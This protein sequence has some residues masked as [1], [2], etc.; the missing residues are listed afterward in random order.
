MKNKRIRLF[1]VIFAMLFVLTGCAEPLHELTEEEEELIVH[2]SAYAVA[3]YN[4]Y[5]KDGMTSAELSEDDMNETEENTESE[6][7]TQDNTGVNGTTGQGNTS[8]DESS[9][10]PKATTSLAKAVG[11]ENLTVTYNGL[12]VSE[13]YQEGGY[14]S[15]DAES[16]RTYLIM[17]FTLKNSTQSEQT[18][19]A[20]TSEHS[21]SIDISGK[22]YS[23][24]KT[25]LTYSLS[26]YQGTLDAGKSVD[27]V[28]LFEVPKG[29]EVKDDDVNLN[30]EMGGTDY[31]V[32]M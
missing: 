25:F 28:L 21:Y 16:G 17:N 8:K 22:N 6:E 9:A 14:Y 1:T 7:I 31:L 11:Q 19:D 18:V 3:K 30:V 23:E 13:H 32:E 2:Y 10:N 27:V 29:T 4:I 12:E 26:T 24:K 15:L 5:Q 20:F